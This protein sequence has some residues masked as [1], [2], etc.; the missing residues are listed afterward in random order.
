M[1]KVGAVRD[2][3]IAERSGETERT[4]MLISLA[5]A[6]TLCAEYSGVSVHVWRILGSRSASAEQ[7]LDVRAFEFDPRRAAVIAL[8]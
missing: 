6:H 1:A 3:A 8:A 2:Q 5:T 4:I 7:A